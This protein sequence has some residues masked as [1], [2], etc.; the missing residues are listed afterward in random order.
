MAEFEQTQE[1][2]GTIPLHTA[3][4]LSRLI[5]CEAKPEKIDLERRANNATAPSHVNERGPDFVEA[6]VLSLLSIF[7]ETCNQTS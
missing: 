6:T 2:F 1:L 4:S 5:H 3:T 7:A